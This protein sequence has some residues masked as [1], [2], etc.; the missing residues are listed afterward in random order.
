MYRIGVCVHI[1]LFILLSGSFAE[2][3]NLYGEAGQ[4]YAIEINVGHPNQK[5]II[6][7]F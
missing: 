3:Y 7:D 2:E 5:V 1:F 6:K 4:A